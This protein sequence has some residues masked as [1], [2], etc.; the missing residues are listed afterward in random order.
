[1]LIKGDEKGALLSEK[2]RGKGATMDALFKK[3]V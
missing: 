3:V 1:M 2:S